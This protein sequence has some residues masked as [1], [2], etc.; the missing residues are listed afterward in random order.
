[1]GAGDEHKVMKEDIKQIVF[2]VPVLSWVPCY[3]FWWWVGA[4][5]ILDAASVKLNVMRVHSKCLF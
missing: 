5:N 4:E 1:M 2:S 3:L